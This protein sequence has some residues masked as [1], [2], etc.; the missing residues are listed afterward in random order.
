M[1]HD[2]VDGYSRSILVF[3]GVN[4]IAAYSFYAPFKTG[5]VSLGQGG[6]MAVGA[7]ASATLTQKFGLPFAVAFPFGGVVAGII[8]VLVGFPALRIKG[9]YLLLLTLGFAEIVSVIALSWDFIGGA[10]GFRQIPFVPSILEY[11]TVVIVVLIL[12]FARIERSSLGRAM[13]AIHQDETAAEVMGVDVVRIKLLAF[14]L[15]AG[16]AGLAGA[17]Y[18]HHATYVDSSTFNIMVGVEILMF[19]VVGGSST[20][21]GP[22]LGAGF[23][24][25][26]PEFLRTL[27]EW[28]ELVPVAWTNFFPM[29]RLY[30]FL[31]EALDFENAKRLIVYGVILIVM[32][33]LRPDGL[34]TR[35]SLRRRCWAGRHA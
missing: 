34:L 35:D 1:L 32:M 22:A 21:W 19:V 23:L 3:T 7:Y 15:G 30:D 29:N 27:R 26:L 5:Q 14:G 25:L 16:I 28:L 18:A 33:I 11:V 8:G 9:V 31:H 6:F 2:L 4:I 24:T 12:L 17:L 20:Y 13:D 10:Q